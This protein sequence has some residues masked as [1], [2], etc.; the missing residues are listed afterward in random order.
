MATTSSFLT[1]GSFA[2]EGQLASLHLRRDS[3]LPVILASKA[4][5]AQDEGYAEGMVTNTRFGSFP[6]S[7][8]I[9]SKWGSQIRASK[10]DTG[11]RGRPNAK[12]RK[13][14]E[15]N[16]TSSNQDDHND[17]TTKDVEL[18]DSGFLHVLPPTPES[19][20]YS[21]PHR[22]QVVYTPDYSYILHRLRARPGTRLI[23]AGSGSGSF[24]HAAARAV[25]NGY[26]T[27][28]DH[29]SDT[30]GRVFSYEFHKE[31]H[32]K[33]L[34][35]MQTHNLSPIVT[36]IHADAYK[37]GFMLPPLSAT[38]QSTSNDTQPHTITNNNPTTNQPRSPNAT[39]IFLDLPAPW[40]A[41]PHLTR[42][43]P[44]SP[45]SP[46]H[47]IHICTFSPC[48]EQA[49]KTISHLRLHSWTSIEMVEISHRRLNILRSYTSL[50]YAGMRG[51]NPYPSTVDEALSHLKS[52]DAR[53][54]DFHEGKREGELSQSV[55]AKRVENAQTEAGKV[56]WGRGEGE[57][58]HRGEG[59][60]KT[61]T[62]YL[63]FAVLPRGWGEEEEGR[64]IKR[65]R[66]KV[67]VRKEEVKS[68]RAMKK[69]A[70]QGRRKKDET[71]IQEGGGP[72]DV[73]MVYK[74]TAG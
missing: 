23:E 44:H 42:T 49:Q 66:G 28:S 59:E 31:R 55:K 40:S 34:T 35:E 27:S 5:S 25:F 48:I 9:G 58:V 3:A 7:T 64:E 72:V 62:S 11:S 2:Q 19:W 29:T 65:W 61:H 15:M 70:Q 21:L 51:V 16:G 50:S 47:P 60:L 26:P 22:T 13:A 74:E 43:S 63:V 30:Y 39:A 69:E 14:N 52:I 56:L 18:A 53:A 68:Q 45:L 20:T 1:P 54:K 12:K 10:V 71:E 33:V 17:S 46:S 73:G 8:I 4:A 24:T 6:H 37:D 36:C 32:E 67:E 41:L 57:I 38:T